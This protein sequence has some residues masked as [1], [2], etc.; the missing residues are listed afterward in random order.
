[1]TVF[2]PPPRP[3][4]P[5]PGAVSIGELVATV[6]DTLVE[7]IGWVTVWGEVSNFKAYGQGNWYFTLKDADA[8]LKAVMFSRDRRFMKYRPKD[9]DEVL[10][11]GRVDVYTQR[12]DLQIIIE[13]MKPLGAGQLQEQFERLK[14][15]LRAEGLFDP[16]RKRP[17]PVVPRRI[18]IVTSL[19][20]A[21]LQDMLRTLSLRDPTLAITIA[22]ARVQGEGAG[23]TIAAALDLL[24]RAADVDV[25]LLGRGG[26][27]LEDLWAFNEEIVA[28]AVA[29]SRIPIICGVGHETDTTI[30]EFVADLRA[31]T[32]TGAAERAV[33][34]R[35]Q[36]EATLADLRARLVTSGQ[37]GLQRRL[38]RTIELRQ[39]LLSPRRRLDLASQRLDDARGR[40]DRALAAGLE[41][42]SQ[43]LRGLLGRLEA[44]DPR[45]ELTAAR[46]RLASARDRLQQATV[47]DLRAR[48]RL[49]EGRRRQLQLV[50]PLQSLER[51]YALASASGQLV[52][53][54]ADV[55]VGDDLRV[56]LHGG[57]LECR[58]LDVIEDPELDLLGR[59]R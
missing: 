18:G 58:V 2:T 45:H 39:R 37:R 3:Q 30:A 42:R 24:N 35:R 55:G 29:R 11:R 36:L 8:S 48:R 41:T 12:G 31:P 16:A 56:R 32:P 26:G 51:G 22:P 54:P 9:G 33:P 5:V 15:R 57:A 38:A 28:R 6:R 59:R 47:V 50:G 13:R 20:A 17:L 10:V 7:R 23:A 14:Q 53:S 34:V 21:A 44:R 46:A 40:L 52:R 19:Q 4:P 25:I 1:M 43:R 27:S 49:V